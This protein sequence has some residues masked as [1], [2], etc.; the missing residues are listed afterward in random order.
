MLPV[1][2]KR[3]RKIANTHLLGTIDNKEPRKKTEQAKLK[4]PRSK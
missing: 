4:Q 1:F 3:L 2:M